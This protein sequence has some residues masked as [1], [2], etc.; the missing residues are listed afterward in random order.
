[1][2]GPEALPGEREHSVA[3]DLDVAISDKMVAEEKNPAL[4]HTYD[5][6]VGHSHGGRTV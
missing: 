4:L 3:L 6:V 5:A 1:M 2:I